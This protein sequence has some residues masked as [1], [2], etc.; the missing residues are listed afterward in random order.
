MT[1]GGRADMMTTETS[2]DPKKTLEGGFLCRF[3]KPSPVEWVCLIGGG[4][5]SLHYAWLMDDAYVYFRYI[6][7]CLFLHRGLVYNAGEYVEGFSSPFWAV[8]LLALRATTLNYWIIIRALC[9]AS[10][11][12]FWFLL[13][14]LNRRL[15]PKESPALNI[16]LILL[17]FHYG[18]LSYF[19][20]GLESPLVQ[21]MAVV[22]ALF[23]LS[24]GNRSLQVLLAISPMLR[25]ELA[26]PLLIGLLWLWY[27]S[28][29]FPLSLFLLS[30]LC[31]GA[32]VLFR[33]YYYA[34]ILPN[35]FYL[36]NDVMIRQGLIYLLDGLSPYHAFCIGIAM[37]SIFLVVRYR[38]KP[39]ADLH[40]SERRMMLFTAF[41]LTVYVVKVG[42]DPRHFRFLSFPY[43]LLVCAYS[44]IVPHA[45]CALSLTQYRKWAYAL[46][47]ALAAVTFSYYPVQ[48]SAHPYPFQDVVEHRIVNEINDAWWHRNHRL[49]FMTPPYWAWGPDFNLAKYKARNAEPTPPYKDTKA[50]PLCYDMHKDFDTRYV[51][52]LGLTDPILARVDV[53]YKRPAHK[54]GLTFLA[55]D[56]VKIYREAGNTPGPG[57]FRRAVDEGRAPEW[58]V[59]NIDTIEMIERRMFNRHHFF[60]NL[61]LALTPIP[62]MDPGEDLFRAI[63]EADLPGR[64]ELEGE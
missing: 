6:D 41:A 1:P 27:R 4:F 33:I 55:N 8:L 18:V 23:F 19:S 45:L 58:I 37:L 36:K 53:E 16:P 21:V 60:E 49:R 63:G 32:W 7:N 5:L 30:G 20:S 50:S 34:D 64:L 51:H 48:L 28:R 61:R 17:S 46:S 59:K 14:L 13:L 40:A 42:G 15:S 35:T 62:R 31:S 2:T 10:F 39:G 12:T 26:L 22:Y 11:V 24:P 57:V 56:M 54:W 3:P 52:S 47:L 38:L 29:R 25:H 43:C 44:G 9:L